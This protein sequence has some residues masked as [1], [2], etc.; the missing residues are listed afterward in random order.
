V[1]PYNEA[2]ANQ[3][4]AGEWSAADPQG[5]AALAREVARQAAMIGYLDAFV[6]FVVT[7][8]VVLPLVLL[9]RWKR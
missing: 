3:S 9:V 5:L 2:L 1:S 4:L 8:L 6:F 7:A